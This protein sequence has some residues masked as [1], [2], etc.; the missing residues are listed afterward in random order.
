[1][2]AYGPERAKQF[3][4]ECG[5]AI[6]AGDVAPAGPPVEPFGLAE[7]VYHRATGRKLG[8]VGGYEDDGRVQVLDAGP[9]DT[10]TL[11]DAAELTT[12]PPAPTPPPAPRPLPT[13]KEAR[14][15]MLAERVKA[16]DPALSLVKIHEGSGSP[17]RYH[18]E[19]RHAGDAGRYEGTHGMTCEG[20]DFLAADTADPL[21]IARFVWDARYKLYGNWERIEHTR[22][23]VDRYETYY[24]RAVGALRRAE[25]DRTIG[26]MG[27]IAARRAFVDTRDELIADRRGNV[28]TWQRQL[29]SYCADLNAAHDRVLAIIGPRP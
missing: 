8:M 15:R 9:F 29:D 18:L 24:G 14:D 10:A 3:L 1:M 28:D 17:K 25:Q 11:Y 21:N 27:Q 6:A 4:A 16:A 13:R 19:I 7:M 5:A 20:F 26:T 23:M 2:I 22:E 12:S